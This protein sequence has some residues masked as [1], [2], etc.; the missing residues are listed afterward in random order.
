MKK[1][2]VFLVCSV[3]AIQL[4]GVGFSRAANQ[5]TDL[6][7]RARAV[8]AQTSGTIELAGLTKPV[9]VL[10]DEWGVPHI[11]AQSQEDLFFAQGFV[12]AQDRLWQMEIWRRTG[13]GKL[14]EALGSAY[15]ERDK[16]ARLMRYRGDMETEWKSYAPDTQRI[17]EAFVNGVN[18]FIETSRNRLPIEFQLT[19]IQPELWTPEVCLTR[20]AGYVMTRNASSEIL[21]AQIVKLFGAEKASELLD[22]DPP[23]KI[24]VPEGL[25][26]NG[27][28]AKILSGANTSISF[29]RIEGS[30][31]WVVS[32]KLSATGKPLL[33]NDP[34]R[35]IQLPSLRYISHLV[36]PGWNVIGAGEP[37]IPGVAAG[38]NERVGFGFTIVGIDQQDLY[39]EDVNPQNPNEFR[40][41][42][43]WEKMRV[44]REPLKVK[45]GQD[46][47]VE[48]K[49]TRHGAVIYE[50][51]NLHRAYALRW[52]GN[53]PGTAG[54][55]ASL[56]LN[57][58]KSWKDFLQALE[59]WKVPSENLVYADVDGNIGW[60]AAGLAPVRKNWNGLLPVP[61]S[62][63]KYE[64]Q[65]YLTVSEMPQTYNPA[66][67]FIATANHNILPAGYKH[68]LNFEFSA[69]FRA[70]RIKE[71][72]S[73][74]K[75]FTIEDFQRLQHDETSLV[76][77]H[78]VPLLKG[79][80]IDD[81]PTRE[82]V[83]LLLNWNFTMSKESA[84]AALFETWFD[85]LRPN[86]F[87]PLVPAEIWRLIGGRFSVPQIIDAL[88]TADP[89]IF[90]A[91]AKAARDT[92]MIKSL[93]EAV[94]DL[95]NQLGAEM[96]AWRWGALH[97]AEFKHQLSGKLAGNAFD[98]KSV[99]RG[100]DA[101]TVNATGGAGYRQTAG[102][103]YRQILDVGNWDNSVA[104]NVPGQSGQ[105]FS[106]HYG[107]LLA[108]WAEGK[109]FPLLYSR[110][111]ILQHTKERL[112]LVPKKSKGEAGIR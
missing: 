14:S 109:Y 62:S 55:L 17:I 57:R 41:Q 50:D 34:H 71:V 97:V 73:A 77:R 40:Y 102:A 98:L 105:P 15:I 20:M 51:K 93:Q 8:L 86:I 37:T 58:A 44:E 70:S 10:R 69:P 7:A 108:L 63:G 68:D 1:A 31:N 27:I 39:V 94:S 54:Y 53:E 46:A 65:G 29:D 23:A 3:F 24:V 35:P 32:G 6:E 9:E 75:N 56:S 91:S 92:A 81:A 67:Q 25:D 95:R 33:A 4:A 104:V 111:K 64:W 26:V 42:G 60:V 87:K 21:R 52:V 66:K 47:E 16:F 61:G 30:N 101:N 89:K 110:E 112:M 107:D 5:A 59:R 12:A 74:G 83:E 13:E 99:A 78:M 36:A 22:T 84:A 2:L 76:A 88:K 90:G 19:G 82:A 11:F 38:H 45:G 28:D 80:K 72:L 49:F 106:P 18:A 96:K 79:I 85:K 43:K 103:S 100:G 48:L